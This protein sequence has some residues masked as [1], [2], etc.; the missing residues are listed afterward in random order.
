MNNDIILR[1]ASLEDESLLFKWRNIEELVLLSYLKKKVDFDEHHQ[2]FINRVGSN[3]CKL[4]IVRIE[5]IDICLVRV[6]LN[7]DEC[8]IS[9]Y[10]IP[11]YE[12]KGYGS[13]ALALALDRCSTLCSCYK[14][15]VQKKNVSSINLFKKLGFIKIY[16][17]DAFATYSKKDR[18]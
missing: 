9:I 8:E 1:E 6:D 15:I 10:L 16:Q 7:D 13:K 17:D 2:W 4:L 5:K 12:G 14:A 3:R 18:S 11:G